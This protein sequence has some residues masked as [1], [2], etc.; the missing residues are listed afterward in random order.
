[1]NYYTLPKTNNK[2]KLEPNISATTIKPYI[3]QTL[4]NYHD[5]IKDEV[6]QLYYYNKNYNVSYDD[7]IKIVNPYE[8]IFSR[9]PGSNYSVS[10]LKTK[11]NMFYEL[12]EIIQTIDL[13]DSFKFDIMNSLIVGENYEDSL[14][15]LEMLRENYNIDKFFC[16]YEYNSKLHNCIEKNKFNFVI[17]ELNKYNDVN[18]N[19]INLL[20]LLVIIFTQLKENSIIIIKLNNTFYKPILEIMYLLNSLFEKTLVVKPNTSDITSFDKY[21]ILQK[22]RLNQ[23]YFDLFNNYNTV[24]SDFIKNYNTKLDINNYNNISSNNLNIQTII[25]HDLPMYFLNKIDDINIIIG[26]QQLEAVNQIIN[27]LKSKNIEDRIEIMKK[28][29]IQKSVN[30]CEKFKIPCN[31]FSDKI[32]IFFQ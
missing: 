25:K 12:F 5:E 28:N 20:E 30:W 9:V 13:L 6:N 8:Y 24:L 15:C 23:Y 18:Q 14:E 11:S 29:N 19:I 27:M 10:K 1:M 3:S 31:K 32:N 16:F 17:Y 21:I 22:L 4:L 26:Q 2:I 7:I